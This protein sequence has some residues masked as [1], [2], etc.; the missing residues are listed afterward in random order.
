VNPAKKW[1]FISVVVALLSNAF[2]LVQWYCIA[3]IIYEAYIFSALRESLL[4]YFFIMAAAIVF[5][6]IFHGIKVKVSFKTSE[7]IRQSLREKILKKITQLGPIQ[8]E[9]KPLSDWLNAI[10]EQVDGL[11]DY[12][13][14]YLPQMQVALLVPMIILVLVFKLSF[15]C[16][17]ILLILAPLIPIFMIIVGMGAASTQKK[18]FQS[19]ARLSNSFLDYVQG[20]V[21]LKLFF[22][23]KSDTIY[24]LSELYRIDTMKVL[25]MAFLSS[26]V[27]DVFSALSIAM[28]AV[29]LGLGFI[30]TGTQNTLFWSLHNLNLQDALFILLLAPEL[31]LP[32][33]DLGTHYHA[34]AK[35]VAAIL[36]IDELTKVFD[37]ENDQDKKK[38]FSTFDI[39]CEHVTVRRLT[40][41]NLSIK[42]NEKLAIIGE[43]GSGKTTL[44]N[45]LLGFIEPSEGRVLI[46]G[47][48]LN[49]Y[50]RESWH[51]HIAWL[52][53]DVKFFHGT[54]RENL[55]FAKPSATD[56]CLMEGLEQ[57]GLSEFTQRLD[58]P[59]SE[60]K[61][62]LSGGQLQ[63][64]GLARLY[65][66]DA[67]VLIL[68]EPTAHL[69]R[70][71]EA[72]VLKAL[73]TFWKDK[74]VIVAT[75]HHFLLDHV[76]RVITFDAGRIVS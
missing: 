37:Q 48:P 73:T 47:T 68:D 52:G 4:P 25:K 58:L 45:T 10:L 40:D 54:I 21:T 23:K 74:T 19:L 35:A 29:Y 61:T 72:I 7:Q 71:Y 57:A 53:Q 63:R 3:H 17:L 15:V 49:D 41:I 50:A 34:K 20:L 24:K 13:M 65:L 43:S 30:N 51:E 60:Q 5:R 59:L 39:Q 31:F 56:A 44:L 42:E 38:S 22:Q 62:G 11:H 33:R 12:L 14:Y 46:N 8:L 16:G 67:K 28:V 26:A 6:A 70:E 66:K 27:L 2:L 36:E 9:N 55:L 64:L 1:V 69:D 18:Y 75:H 32:L 76:D